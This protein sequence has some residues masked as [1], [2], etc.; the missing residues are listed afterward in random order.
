MVNCYQETAPSVMPRLM[1][2]RSYPALITLVLLAISPTFPLAQMPDLAVAGGVMFHGTEENQ[3]SIEVWAFDSHL[4]ITSITNATTVSLQGNNANGESLKATEDS[5]GDFT[6][7]VNRVTVAINEG[8][9]EK[10]TVSLLV[11]YTKDARDV[12]TG[13]VIVPSVH[14]YGTS[15]ELDADSCIATLNGEHGVIG[16]WTE[17]HKTVLNNKTLNFG[18]LKLTGVSGVINWKQLAMSVD[19]TGKVEEPSG[20]VFASF[21]NLPHLSNRQPLRPKTEAQTATLPSKNVLDPQVQNK[22]ILYENAKEPQFQD[23]ANSQPIVAEELE[24]NITKY[25]LIKHAAPKYPRR[26]LRRGI[27][28]KVIVE[29]CISEDGVPHSIKVVDELPSAIFSRS[30]VESVQKYRFSPQLVDGAPVEVCGVT[31]RVT[32][33]V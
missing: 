19:D 1:P 17:D 28:G 29:L 24:P 32:F 25:K 16:R 23:T 27:S 18:G 9:N 5:I 6:D 26:A 3:G 4:K 33:E 21:S 30:A 13:D 20:Y 14:C 12:E 8:D 22:E 11:H 2:K 15:D 7:G 10:R 31:Y